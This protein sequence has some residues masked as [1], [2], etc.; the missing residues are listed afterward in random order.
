MLSR[1][2]FISLTLA[3][4]ASAQEATP[5][6]TVGDL[7]SI[8][9]PGTKKQ[10]WFINDSAFPFLPV[11]A[12]TG[13][14]AFLGDAVVGRYSGPDIDHLSVT[15]S[16][17]VPVSESPGVDS[18]WRANG[19]WMLTATRISDGTLV[20]FVHGEDHHFADGGYGEW[21]STGVWT[22]TDDGLTWLDHG[23]VL[24]SQKPAHHAFGGLA[25]NECI[26]DPAAK[27]WLGYAAGGYVFTSADIHAA[28]GTWYGYNKGA[29]SSHINVNALAP[30]LTPA[31]GLQ[32]A[33]LTWGGLTYNRYL[34]RYILSWAAGSRSVK[35]AFSPDGL[36]W[37]NVLTLY[38]D[39]TPNTTS[40]DI[41]Y[42]FIV[43]E[44]D[45]LSGQDCNLVYMYHPPGKTVSGNRKDVVRRPIHF[46]KNSTAQNTTF[47]KAATP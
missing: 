13:I 25:M 21:N 11:R 18:H 26:W 28:P 47:E 41:T 31:P 43:G 19:G 45:T 29:F 23:E 42:A 32:N 37:D 5:F 7:H 9:I 39:T 17:P 14:M 1:L 22:S 33:D 44:T 15:G 35:A 27:R 40:D 10:T 6:F 24:G 3:T 16:I 38:S 8:P 36:H 30:S 46:Q 4:L 2:L 34:Q 20:A 12:G